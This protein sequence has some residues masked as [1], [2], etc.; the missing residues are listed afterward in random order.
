MLLGTA[1]QLQLSGT[2]IETRDVTG[3]LLPMVD[4]LQ[5]FGLILDCHLHYDMHT[6]TVAKVGSYHL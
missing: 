2:V 4:E 5:T 1:L 6:S 3:I